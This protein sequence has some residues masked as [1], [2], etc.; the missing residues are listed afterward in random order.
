M[1]RCYYCDGD[2]QEH[3]LGCPVLD[4]ELEEKEKASALEDFFIDFKPLDFSDEDVTKE[5]FIRDLFDT[6]DVGSD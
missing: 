6:S 1:K 5:L 4:I 2:E 3:V